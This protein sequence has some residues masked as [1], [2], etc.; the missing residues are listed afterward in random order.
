MWAQY[1]H[2]PVARKTWCDAP[3]SPN[4]EH[5]AMERALAALA[6]IGEAARRRAL[7][8]VNPHATAVSERLRNL[9]IHALAARYEVEAVET[10]R[11]GHATE[12][13]RA[14]TGDRYDLVIA[15]GG[16]GTVNEVANG[17]A[18]SL[19]PLSCLP[20]GSANVYC[21][22]LGIPGEIVDATE[23]LLRMA[24]RFAPRQVDLGFVEGRHYTFSAGV[25]IDADVVRRVDGRPALKR[26]FGPWFFTAVACAVVAR[27][28]LVRPPRMLVET[29]AGTFAGVTAIVQN[30][31][32]YT[33]FNEHPVDL[34]PD[35][36]LD[37][38]T[39]SGVVLERGS[40]LDVPGLLLRAV[41]RSRGV[42]G[43]RRVSAFVTSDGAS[44]VSAD[45]RRLPL[46]LDGDYIG[47][48]TEA[49]FSVV[50]GGL[51]VLA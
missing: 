10:L 21:K 26:R 12:I 33:Y 42:A 51:R 34:A 8:I 24:D 27:S 49:H 16:D 2:A 35:A 29:A 43:H 18:G 39:L 40:P 50:P 25:G 19:V 37:S 47:E 13:A 48:V 3:M 30:G 4:A 11:S 46:Q 23:H 44:V 32:H 14:A 36:A 1:T 22:L 9:V 20:G 5:D 17:L 31:E 15:F 41:G 28:Y 6:P 38:G 7:V 45:A